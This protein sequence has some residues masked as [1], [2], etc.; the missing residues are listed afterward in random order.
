M[1]A[2]LHLYVAD[3]SIESPMLSRSFKDEIIYEGYFRHGDIL[4]KEDSLLLEPNPYGHITIGQK[5][6]MRMK[7]RI[8]LIRKL[9]MSINGKAQTDPAEALDE[10]L[11]TSEA[12]EDRQRDPDLL[13]LAFQQ[14]FAF[15]KKTAG[16][17]PL[18]HTV[19]TRPDRSLKNKIEFI[20][21]DK[22]EY[23]LDGNLFYYRNY[24]AWRHKLLV[25][26]HGDKVD[27]NFHVEVKPEIN[28]G[29][30][31]LY[32]R[33]ITKAEEFAPEFAGIDT[34]LQQAIKENKKVFWEI[35]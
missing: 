5:K 13:Q 2:A 29:G 28:L 21:I 30:Q 24:P 3:N 32:T 4:P 19:H 33:T 22:K 9:A 15:M 23:Y 34:F 35:G 14:V 11:E 12:P 26:A 31:R 20:T 16:K 8:G 25:Q 6:K 10:Y 18:L 1:G 17:L 27:K 7:D